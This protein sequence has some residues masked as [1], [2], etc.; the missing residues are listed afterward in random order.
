MYS[1]LRP[2]LDTL[3]CEP[4]VRLRLCIVRVLGLVTWWQKITL[5]AFRLYGDTVNLILQNAHHVARDN[6]LA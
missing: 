3:L 4:N 5:L 2:V 6:L 1:V